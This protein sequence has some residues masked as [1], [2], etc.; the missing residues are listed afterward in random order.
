VDVRPERDDRPKLEVQAIRPDTHAVLI[1]EDHR[2]DEQALR[3][4]LPTPA[5]YLGMIGSRQK[6]RTI[7]EHLRNEGFSEDQL[8]RLH[9]PIGLDLGGR[10][11]AQIALAIL[12]EIEMVRHGGTGRP[13]SE[14]V[15]AGSASSV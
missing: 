2:T 15:H 3:D 12:A 7:V 1:T 14:G 9:G 4:L 5:A 10:E 8:S 13:R 11:P 6:I